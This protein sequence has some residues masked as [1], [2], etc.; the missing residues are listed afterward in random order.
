MK[1]F[2]LRLMAAFLFAGAVSATFT[3]CASSSGY[4]KNFDEAD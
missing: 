3:G 1:K 4:T 2:L